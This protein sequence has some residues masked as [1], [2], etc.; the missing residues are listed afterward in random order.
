[1]HDYIR[2][3]YGQMPKVSMTMTPDELV[4]A[5]NHHRSQH[6]YHDALACYAQAFALDAQ[7]IH[8]WNNYGN[9]MRELGYPDRARPFLAYARTLDP[10]FVHAE[11][12]LAVT[13]LLAGNYEQGWPLYESRWRYE[14]LA[15]TRPQMSAPE[16]QGEPLNN[17]T[18]LVISEQGYGDVIQF[19]RFIADLHAQGATV[20]LETLPGLVPVM[21]HSH[22][23]AQC[24]ANRQ[25][26]GQPDYWVS[27]MSLP[28]KLHTGSDIPAAL[29]YIRAQPE[30]VQ[31]WRTLLPDRSAMRIGICWS[32]RSD[33]WAN[34]YKAVPVGHW[35][36]LIQAFPEHAWISLQ[37]Q[38]CKQD[39]AHMDA[40]R[41]HAY[42][43]RIQHW[44]HT[45]G[46]IDQ[47]DLVISVDTAVA[48]MAAAL[49]KTTW[50]PTTRY[51]VDWRWGTQGMTTPWYPTVK[52]F[53]QPDYADWSSVMANMHRHLKH[54]KV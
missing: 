28:G 5:G 48:H 27:L 20:W 31:A 39:Q 13:E 54:F 14:H 25:S 52:L 10:D 21:E 15:G 47:L 8:A 35:D 4:N 50:I 9:V 51:A 23:I 7:N 1:M 44:G 18:I 40:L 12:N 38:P 34:Q 24:H 42:P 49:G 6:R 22:M 43:G 37:A 17:K 53:R 2:I 41:V 29:S 11:F 3:I 19:V 16:W 46:L 32:G 45:A 26:F 36:D 33:N 30:Y